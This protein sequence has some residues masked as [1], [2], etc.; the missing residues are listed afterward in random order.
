M[1]FN[2]RFRKEVFGTAA[3]LCAAFVLVPGFTVEGLVPAEARWAAGLAVERAGLV[4]PEGCVVPVLCAA[5]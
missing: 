4:C 1:K 2:T 3:W 5:L